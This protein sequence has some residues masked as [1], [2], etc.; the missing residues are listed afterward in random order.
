MTHAHLTKRHPY[1][2]DLGTSRPSRSR[3]RSENDINRVSRLP[4]VIEIALMY[5][6]GPV[7]RD[8][9]QPQPPPFPRRS[10]LTNPDTRETPPARPN[11]RDPDL[12]VV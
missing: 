4:E 10:E 5:V 11:Q 7:D 1:E 2:C 9:T 12:P 6:L 8:A 3:Y